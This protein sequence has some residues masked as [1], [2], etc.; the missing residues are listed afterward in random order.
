MTED[1]TAFGLEPQD[2]PK[3]E[4]GPAEDESEQVWSQCVDCEYAGYEVK[5]RLQQP[6]PLC[7]ACFVNR[8]GLR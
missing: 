7:P 3:E 1:L 6:V 5:T 8:E 2:P 4:G